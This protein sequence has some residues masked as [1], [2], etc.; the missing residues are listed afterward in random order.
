[1]NECKSKLTDNK[2]CIELRNTALWKLKA[3]LSATALHSGRLPSLCLYAMQHL[4]EWYTLIRYPIGR[5]LSDNKY[6]T[7]P[8]SKK[9]KSV[10]MFLRE[11]GGE[12]RAGGREG[13]GETEYSCISIWKLEKPILY[14]TGAEGNGA[15]SSLTKWCEVRVRFPIWYKVTKLYS[16]ENER[17]RQGSGGMQSDLAG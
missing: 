7:I 9:S 16:D 5:I 6:V 13:E 2:G 11:R 4:A 1:M 3:C 12:G 14:A 8:N 10:K 15:T 17:P